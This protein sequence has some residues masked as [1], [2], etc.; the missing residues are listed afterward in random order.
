M[1]Q[2]L[3]R[4]QALDIIN[5]SVA[6]DEKFTRMAN[7]LFNQE[8]S[9]RLMQKAYD[10]GT[11][12]AKA[13]LLDSLETQFLDKYA[14]DADK[15]DTGKGK[16]SKT[17]D[18]GS[19]DDFKFEEDGSQVE[20]EQGSDGEGSQEDASQGIDAG[21]ALDNGNG[22]AEPSGVEQSNPFM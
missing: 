16:D 19:D 1:Q 7:A 5:E 17:E 6:P 14:P 15:V 22:S 20:D 8:E 9:K 21:S 2:K 13:S 18:D 4:E 3:T 11:E 12:D 10:E